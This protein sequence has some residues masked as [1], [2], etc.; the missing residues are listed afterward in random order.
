[1]KQTFE[2]FQQVGEKEKRR[3]R[4]TCNSSWTSPSQIALLSW[5][6]SQFLGIT[7]ESVQKLTNLA[8]EAK[9]FVWI[10]I[11]PKLS[12]ITQHHKTIKLSNFL[13][14]IKL[15]LFLWMKH[16]ILILVT[17]AIRKFDLVTVTL[18]LLFLWELW[19]F[20]SIKHGQ[21]YMVSHILYRLSLN[22]IW[23]FIFLFVSRF[24]KVF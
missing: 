8:M 21:I 1:M 22:E 4:L 3:P 10:M 16:C 5:W 7:T 24:K 13:F 14:E 6:T 15:Y 12:M 9:V 17:N 11:F 2:S 18:A 20:F 19:V 23:I